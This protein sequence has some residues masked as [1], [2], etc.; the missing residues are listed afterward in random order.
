MQLQTILNRVT[1]YKP[2]V[3]E[4][5]SWDDKASE[6]TLR[7][8]MRARK[9]G[10]AVCSGCG[11]RC[12]GYDR[13]PERTWEFVPLWQ[14]AVLLVYS[15]RR[16]DC[17]TCG[18]VVERVPWGEGKCQQTHEY[19]WFL[20]R[21]ARRLSWSE[22]ARI[23]GSSW[24]TVYRAVRHVV[25]WGLVHRELRGVEAIGVDEI[26]YQRGHKYLTVVYQIQEGCRRLLW[27]GRERTEKS[28]ERFF[29]LLR[30]E[31]AAGSLRVQRHVEALP[32][33]DPPASW[34]RSCR[35]S[36]GSTSWPD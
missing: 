7:V 34:G 36:I 17:E 5:S 26:Q 10:Q 30:E 1:R 29:D 22:T 28:L 32:G 15:P 24:N 12:A 35:F 9:N 11:K 23:F 13:L 19:Y 21:W 3:F 2:F 14:I 18:V 27:V 8:R 25:A 20:A 33:R 31:I 4:S 6:P 16:V